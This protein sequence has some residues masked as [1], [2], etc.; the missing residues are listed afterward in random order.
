MAE[1]ESGL[2][3]LKALLASPT[4]LPLGEHWWGAPAAPGAEALHQS[5]K[6][7]GLVRGLESRKKWHL[8]SVPEVPGG[9]QRREHCQ[10]PYGSHVVPP[11]LQADGVTILQKEKMKPEQLISSRPSCLARSPCLFHGL[12]QANDAAG[13]KAVSEFTEHLIKGS[14]WERMGLK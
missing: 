7:E 5:Q 10:M 11:S 13:R 1:H 12:M 14:V 8:R 4:S 3:Y 6:Q 2:K 9:R